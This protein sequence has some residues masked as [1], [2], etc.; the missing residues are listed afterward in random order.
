[1]FILL[2]FFSIKTQ[3]GLLILEEKK[4]FYRSEV[5]SNEN[6]SKQKSTALTAV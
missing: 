2:L 4:T 6:E 1:M 3:L 5:Q